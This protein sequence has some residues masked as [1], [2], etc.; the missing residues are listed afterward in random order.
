MVRLL[1]LGEL[2]GVPDE[3]VEL[4]LERVVLA[5]KVVDQ[6][7]EIVVFLEHPLGFRLQILLDGERGYILLCLA[8]QGFQLVLQLPHVL[9]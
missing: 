1:K 7:K 9:L 2:L 3:G 5:L 6:F 8:A 4:L